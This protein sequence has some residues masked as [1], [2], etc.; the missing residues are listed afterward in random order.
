[1]RG[2]A[3]EIEHLREGALALSVDTPMLQVQSDT[4]GPY[5]RNSGQHYLAYQILEVGRYSV[6]LFGQTN[7]QCFAFAVALR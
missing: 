3:S 1:M 2:A 5:V 4:A 6:H 7:K